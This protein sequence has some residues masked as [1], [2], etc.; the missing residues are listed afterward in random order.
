M[1]DR[2]VEQDAHHLVIALDVLDAALLS[3]KVRVSR[4]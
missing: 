1:I 2:M 4:P 3:S